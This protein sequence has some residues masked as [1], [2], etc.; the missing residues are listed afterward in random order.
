M[1]CNV[2]VKAAKVA[3]GSAD[4]AVANL[5]CSYK[6]ASGAQ[7]FIEPESITIKGQKN[8]KAVIGED[9][10]SITVSNLTKNSG[11]VKLTL[12]FH[13]GITKNVTVKV[14]K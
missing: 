7:H 9:K 12:G 5:V 8:V 2:K 6:D 3:L 14:K 1:P 10:M 4:A 11:S 13:G